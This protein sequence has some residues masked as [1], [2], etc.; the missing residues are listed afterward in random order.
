MSG[1]GL[2]G[3]RGAIPS[4]P[5][6]G[7]A[8]KAILRPRRRHPVTVLSDTRNEKELP[9]HHPPKE[10]T[11]CHG[12][13]GYEPPSTPLPLPRPYPGGQPRPAGERRH[14]E[15]DPLPL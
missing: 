3:G 11:S 13:M 1:Q 9:H 5:L 15:A 12:T 10:V 14:Q 2:H 8:T 6:G 4:Q 7:R